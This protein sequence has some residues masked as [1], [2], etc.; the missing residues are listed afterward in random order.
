MITINYQAFGSKGFQLRLRLYQDGETRFINVTK[1]LKGSIQ[2]KHWNQK[3]Q[4]FIPSCPFSEENNA[5]LVQFRQRYDKAAIEWTGSLYGMMAA[6]EMEESSSIK[7]VTISEFIKFIIEKLGKKK[8]ADGSTK[9][10]FEEYV[11]CE[12]RLQEFCAYKRID[13]SKILISELT[14]P[15]IDNVFEWVEKS[16]N[17]NGMRYISKTLH[18]II[19]KAE[20]EGYLKS[21]DFKKCNWYKKRDVST[22]KYNT[23]S[24]EQ[25]KKFAQLNLDEI[26]KSKYNELF[27][28]F[29]FFIL[30]TGQ[31]ACDA[32]TL[33]YSDIQKIGGIS[34]FVFK[35]RKIAEKQS[36]PCAVPI[37]QEMDRIMLRWKHLAKDGYVFPVRSKKKI[38]TQGTNNGDIKHFIGNLNNWLKK[39]GKALGC[40]FPL[41]TYTFRHTAITH[42]ISKGVP[43]IYVSNMMGTSVESCERIYYNNQGDTSSRNKVLTAMKF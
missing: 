7:N 32:L 19:M 13:Y 10:S 1:L 37:N 43:I 24:E 14:A 8:H 34:H 33:R 17:G 6:L 4:L 31:S 12:K 5:I 41:H 27:R 22:Q 2:K 18:S 40:S 39:I 36:V 30:Y 25:I 38:E 29:C 11:K 21:E 23:L 42:Y 16:R 28:D 26:Y 20:V 9:G 3:K 35:R 15:F